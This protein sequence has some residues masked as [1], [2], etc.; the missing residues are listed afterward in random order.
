MFE[1]LI[2]VDGLVGIFGR[3]IAAGFMSA[4]LGF[5]TILDSLESLFLSLL[6]RN[7]SWYSFTLLVSGIFFC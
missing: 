1:C 3:S 5:S 4:I 2:G 7:K 6:C